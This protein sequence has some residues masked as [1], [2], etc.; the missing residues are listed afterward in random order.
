MS[1]LWPENVATAVESVRI[2]AKRA[3]TVLRTLHD[4][5]THSLPGASDEL[6]LDAVYSLGKIEEEIDAFQATYP[7]RPQSRRQLSVD[8]DEH[9][10]G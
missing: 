6:L 10:P 4:E 7:I 2:H 3:L 9:R 1:T 8:P 5:I